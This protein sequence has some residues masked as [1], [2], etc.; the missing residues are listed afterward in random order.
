[1]GRR[2]GENSVEII[3]Y[4]EPIPKDLIEM[5]LEVTM[6]DIKDIDLKYFKIEYSEFEGEEDE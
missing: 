2:K 6:K 1:M 4:D 5:I 3:Q